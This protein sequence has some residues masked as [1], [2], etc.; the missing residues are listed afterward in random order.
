MSYFIRRGNA[1]TVS[2]SA[3]LDIH[4]RLPT[5]NY[6]VKYSM[7]EGF[8]LEM[9]EPH[10]KQGKIYGNTV[11]SAER[12]MSTFESRPYG[13]GVLLSGEKGSGKT[14]LAKTLS[15]MGAENDYPTLT[16]NMPLFGDGFNKFMQDINTPCVVIFDEFEKVYDD[17]QQQ[18]LLTL[19]DGVYPTKKLFI[20]TC[21]NQWRI[22]SHMRNRPGRIFYSM[23][24]KG[25]DVDFIREYCEDNLNNKGHIE[26]VCRASVLFH[27][28]NFDMLKALVEEMNRY[29]ETASEAMVM[30]NAKP[31]DSERTTYDLTVSV[32]GKALEAANFAPAAWTGNPVKT[33]FNV[34]LQKK[35]VQAKGKVVKLDAVKRKVAKRREDE[36][37][38]DDDDD[39]EENLNELLLGRDQ[40]AVSIL[41]EEHLLAVDPADGTFTFQNGS[42]IVVLKKR[43]A[44]NEDYYSRVF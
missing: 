15:I 3:K 7:E 35:A 12:I 11:K 6:T 1:F 34:V 28:F 43:A 16:I 38:D 37:G 17:E 8:Y 23:D 41:P 44:I 29:N 2:D 26:S 5:G 40:M 9:I 32:S 25:L 10:K 24:F 21:N 33:A 4:E 13:T 14:L 18:S 20:L 39:F 22:D 30:L 19:F 27:Q 31:Q 36:F 42:V